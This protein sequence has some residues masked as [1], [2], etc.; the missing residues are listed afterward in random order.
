M[1]SHATQGQGKGAAGLAVFEG[2]VREVR[3]GEGRREVEI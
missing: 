1:S 2:G 3:G